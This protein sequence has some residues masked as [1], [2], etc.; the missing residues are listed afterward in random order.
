MGTLIAHK[1]REEYPDRMINT[2]SVVPSSKVS[3]TMV[4]P[5]NAV[6]SLHTLLDGE[7][8]FIFLANIGWKKFLASDKKRLNFSPTFFYF[9]PKFSNPFVSIVILGN[10]DQNFDRLFIKAEFFGPTFLRPTF[11]TYKGAFLIYEATKMTSPVVCYSRES[12][13]TLKI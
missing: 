6:L 11:L 3:N 13:R 12:S 9:R 10:S 7:I 4:E 8:V 5:Y 2:F 1:I